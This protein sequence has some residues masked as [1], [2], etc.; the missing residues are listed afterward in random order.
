MCS[1]LQL[2]PLEGRFARGDLRGPLVN[3]PTTRGKTLTAETLSYYSL[4]RRACARS[5]SSSCMS[6]DSVR[7]SRQLSDSERDF[8]P[9]DESEDDLEAFNEE[10]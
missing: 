9:T 3:S 5:S 1:S 10:V 2:S 6:R 4:P 7:P 8:I